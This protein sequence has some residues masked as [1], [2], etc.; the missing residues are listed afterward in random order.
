MK[1][2]TDKLKEAQARE[3]LRSY[4]LAYNAKKNKETHLGDREPIYVIY[5]RRSREDETN[6][7]FS[8]PQ[9]IEV[10]QKFAKDN[11]LTIADI[12]PEDHSAKTAGKRERFLEMLE[13]IRKG[14]SYN[15][16]LSWHPDRLARNMK[17]AGEILDMLDNDYIVDLKFP[18]YT[19][20]N[21]AA[22]KMTLSI[23]F[24]MAK[25]FSDKLSEDT[26]RG[27][28]KKVEKGFYVGTP[29][30][31]YIG[32][33]DGFYKPDRNTFDQYKNAWE[34][35]LKGVSQREISKELEKEDPELNKGNLSDYFKD[36]FSAGF[37]CYGNQ[38]V[39]LLSVDPNF[40]PMVSA[41]DFIA[42][43]KQGRVSPRGWKINDNFR[44][45]RDFVKCEDCGSYMI[46]GVSKGKS[47]RY[48]NVTCGNNKCREIRRSKG[49]KPI[50]NT[51][52]GKILLDFATEFINKNLNVTKE[53][54]EKAKK[55]YFEE[56]N[57]LTKER[58]EEIRRLNI[59]IASLNK[60]IDQY[61][62]K[63]LEIKDE[64]ITHKLTKDMKII[65]RERKDLKREVEEL[66]DLNVEAEYNTNAEFPDYDLFVNFFK[67]I[68][69]TIENTENAYLIDQLVKLV[70]VNISV[71]DKK[72]LH[73]EL[74]EPF[75]ALES[76]K[77]L[78]GVGYMT[79]L[80]TLNLK[81]Y[82]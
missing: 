45:F 33:V 76:M 36:P 43:Q 59:R 2:S 62:K 26:K 69:T 57:L 16:I 49:V 71:G 52:R 38:V 28:N 60:S 74:R 5:A 48:L 50:A 29:K 82:L 53:I 31:G 81:T 37:Y 66:N 77:N 73:Y 7:K 4:A 68:V 11:N 61:S 23:L 19:F 8:V 63:I 67:N 18:S 58:K 12:I 34:Q 42:I 25:E 35:C 30:K 70:F 24:A 65:L 44:P 39:D 32:Q 79:L 1:E 40:K 10:C 13:N 55:I 17:E 72:V 56:I 20:N 78:S 80:R 21:D 27:N 51:I 3:L 54:Y 46:P 47:D 14:D 64:E 15:A 75:N 6:Q 9:Q 22:G 41:S